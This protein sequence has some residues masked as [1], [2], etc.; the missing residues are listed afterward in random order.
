[1]RNTINSPG[2]VPRGLSSAAASLRPNHDARPDAARRPGPSRWALQG[3]RGWSVLPRFPRTSRH[4]RP[5]LSIAGREGHRSLPGAPPAHGGPGRSRSPR[6]GRGFRP[7]LTGRARSVPG[8]GRG[9]A[10]SGDV[11]LKPRPFVQGYIRGGA[12]AVGLFAPGLP[13]SP[14]R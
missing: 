1:M 8:R 10:G 11:S 3:G 14:R 5:P 2:A 12:H 4:A 13:P 7:A 6:P 9:A